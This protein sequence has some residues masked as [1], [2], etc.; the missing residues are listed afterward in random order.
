MGGTK[1]QKMDGFSSGTL[2]LADRVELRSRKYLSLTSSVDEPV[3]Q[4]V[5]SCALQREGSIP[6]F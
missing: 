4:Q 1:T 3:G 2:K 5:L 6:V